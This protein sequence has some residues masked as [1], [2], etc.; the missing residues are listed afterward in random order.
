MSDGQFKLSSGSD[1]KTFDVVAGVNKFKLA[2]KPGQIR[3][4]L[5]RLGVEIVDVDP[6]SAFT[7]TTSPKTYNFN[8]FMASN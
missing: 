5:S 6:G 3:G 7:Y 2:N 8:N 1:S 4:T